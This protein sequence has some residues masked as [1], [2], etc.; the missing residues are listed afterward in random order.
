MTTQS[1]G[2]LNLIG[3]LLA[4][5]PVRS[6]MTDMSESFQSYVEASGKTQKGYKDGQ[7]VS[8]TTGQKYI[9]HPDIR[10][11]NVVKQPS[12]INRWPGHRC[13]KVYQQEMVFQRNN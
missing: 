7:R 12:E 1:A 4:A 13:R 2:G 11:V 5:Q 9:S 3:N 6:Q 10:M 8:S